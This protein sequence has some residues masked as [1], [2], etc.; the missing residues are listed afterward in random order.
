MNSYHKKSI[1]DQVSRRAGSIKG[2]RQ[3]WLVGLRESDLPFG[4]DKKGICYSAGILF[5]KVI[6]DSN[7]RSRSF[8]F[9]AKQYDTLMKATIPVHFFPE[10]LVICY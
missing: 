10:T 6:Q 3:F 5:K 2:S 9:K 8:I 1:K 7:F 4:Y